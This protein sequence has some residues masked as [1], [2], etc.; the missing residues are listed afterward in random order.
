VSLVFEQLPGL[1]PCRL[2]P[3]DLKGPLGVSAIDTRLMQSGELFWALVGESSDGH[4]YITEAFARG[5]QAAVVSSRWFMECGNGRPVGAYI[6]VDDPLK[7]LQNLAAAHRRRF[8]ISLIA[9]TGSNGKTATK[10]LLGAALS[11]KYRMVKNTGNF[12]NHI[13]VPLTLLGITP[14]TEIILTEMGS[15]HPGEIAALCRIA[16]PD[17]GLVLNV[18]PAHLEGFG[19]LEAVAHEKASLLEALPATGTAFVNLD[20]ARV[21]NMTSPAQTRICFGFERQL[22]AG[23]CQTIRIAKAI[24][25][26]QGGRGGFRLEG[27]T[28]SLNWPGLH[29]TRNA[30][31]AA[32]VAQHFNVPSDQ[33][34]AAFASLPPLPGRLQIRETGGVTI[35]DDSYNANPASTIAALEFLHSLKTAKRRFAVLGDNLELGSAGEELHRRLGRSLKSHRLRGVYLIGP[36]MALAWQECADGVEA[37][38]F[39]AEDDYGMI[40]N[41]IAETLKPGDAILVKASHGMKLD[42]IVK[43][44]INRLSSL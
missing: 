21:R 9:L 40:T 32:V 27:E 35:I 1:I 28:Y 4:A 17:A 12:N 34:A 43:G 44:L 37:E 14:E 13:G 11:Q 8:K 38:H 36:L 30:L 7:S 22:D 2:H 19:T 39:S 23:S 29:Q 3:A 6:V 5:A 24:S 15:N 20:D 42:R 41:R 25:P 10:E 26:T 18:G 33:I 31:A 16:A